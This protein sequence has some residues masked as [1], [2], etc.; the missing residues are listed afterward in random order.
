ML[1]YLVQDTWSAAHAAEPAWHR[2]LGLVGPWVLA[3]AVAALVLRALLQH[4]RYRALGV[5]SEADLEL[6]HA[7]L[8]AAESKTVGEIV[9]VVVERSDRHPDARWFAALM[10]V[11]VGS[12]V[13]EPHLAWSNPPLVLAEQIA[14]G[15]LGYALAAWLPGFARVFVREKRATEVAEEQA[16]QEFLGLDL[17]ATAGASGVLIFVSLFERRVVVLADGGIASV[18]AP[19]LWQHVDEAVLRGVAGGN[20]RD[21]LIAGIE[22]AGAVLAE[23]F[24]VR[25][26]DR[27]ELP[28]RVVVRRE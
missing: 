8:R 22:R 16:T 28:D 1:A 23:H 18:A 6:V 9:P 2:W 13:L 12:A 24:P 15:A 25:A 3:G 10:L 4:R 17:A 27:N 26:G 11:L 19:D 7:A 21:G 5:L 20:L 14:L